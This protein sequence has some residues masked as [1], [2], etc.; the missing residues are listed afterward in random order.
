M[1]LIIMPRL[2]SGYRKAGKYGSVKICEW[3]RKSLR[4]EGYCYKQKFYGIESHRCIQ[5]TPC[6]EFCTHA[7]LFCWRDISK[8]K[9]KIPEFKENVS[10]FLD[11]AIKNHRLLLTGFKGNDKT[12]RNKFNEAYNP[13]H[14]AISLSG[15]PTLYPFLSEL[16]KEINKRK[17]TSFLVTNGTM[18]EVLK[19]IKMPTQLYITL[20]AYDKET[21]EKTCNPLIADGW[22]KLLKSLKLMSKLKTRKVIRLTL[23]KD[24]NF[25][26]P[27]KYA[28]LIKIAKPDFVEAKSYMAVGYSRERISYEK[29]PSFAEIKEFSRELSKYLDYTLINE[30]EDSRVCLLSSGIKQPLI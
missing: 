23:V 21:Y 7:C 19:K 17:M 16:I 15:E 4:N 24:L 8:T 9:V 26:N 12:P 1:V 30:K 14:V 18:P 28:E 10:E 29:M 22:D 5:L 25:S 20:A 3:T 11:E 13:K 6:K 27:E 2:N